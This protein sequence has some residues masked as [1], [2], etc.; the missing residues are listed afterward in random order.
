MGPLKVPNN[1]GLIGAVFGTQAVIT[2]Q[3]GVPALGFAVTNGLW[4][5]PGFYAP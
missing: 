1:A 3:N 2:G 4:L 5:A